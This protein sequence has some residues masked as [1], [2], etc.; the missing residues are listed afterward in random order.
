MFLLIAVIP[1]LEASPIVYGFFS[2]PDATYTS[3]W[4]VN[5]SGV[6]AGFYAD[7][8]SL[9]HGFI[10]SADGSSYTTVDFPGS[11]V[12][13]T[14]VFGIND[15]GDVAGTYYDGALHPFIRSADGTYSSFS[16]P[17]LYTFADGINNRGQIEGSTDTQGYIRG[18][19]GAYTTFNVPGQGG[20]GFIQPSG[21]INDAGVV[22]GTF[23]DSIVYQDFIRS[24][25]AQYIVF[26][27][28]GFAISYV[29]G[30]NNRGEVV[31]WG[32]ES[33][34]CC[35][36]GTGFVRSGDGSTYTILETPLAPDIRAHGINDLGEIVGGAAGFGQGGVGFCTGPCAGS[37][38]TP[39][40]EP[41]T[42]S[43]IVLFG[44]LMLFRRRTA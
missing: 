37:S 18:G 39:L 2:A 33:A 44:A 12:S 10:R 30:I 20:N 34:N 5:N 13:S 26:Q 40:P 28:R 7:E 8:N 19:N 43:T 14:D 24:A 1:G 16:L 23:F 11:N 4:A 41:S 42:L 21:G 27:P 15:R 25:Q 9:Q 38:P 3:A 22:T 35:G 32:F 29:F 36:F 6:I 31:G 17:G